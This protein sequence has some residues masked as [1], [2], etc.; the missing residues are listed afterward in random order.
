MGFRAAEFAMPIEVT[1]T[2][3]QPVAARLHT[4]T[5]LQFSNVAS[6]IIK[7]DQCALGSQGI[8]M[9]RSIQLVAL[10]SVMPTLRR[11]VSWPEHRKVVNK[12]GGIE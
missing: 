8:P 1:I 2:N 9:D 12:R 11:A 3:S 6:L 10:G 4:G 5:R 7:G